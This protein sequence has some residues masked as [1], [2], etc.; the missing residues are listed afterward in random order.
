LVFHA[1]GFGMGVNRNRLWKRFWRR[2]L[3]KIRIA[4]KEN[5]VDGKRTH[6]ANFIDV[7]RLVSEIA[8][9][10]CRVAFLSFFK[11]ICGAREGRARGRFSG[12]ERR[13]SVPAPV[14]PGHETLSALHF[15]AKV[16]F[17]AR[18]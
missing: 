11:D 13:S 2:K 3:S 18:E 1:G 16:V 17:P 15:L 14:S 5:L 9:R 8:I 7:I 10:N 12:P 4:N 6:V